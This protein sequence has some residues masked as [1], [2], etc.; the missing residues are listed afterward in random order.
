MVFKDLKVRKDEKRAEDRVPWD[1]P[2]FRGQADAQ[3]P[4]RQGAVGRA[5]KAVSQKTREKNVQ[6]ERSNCLC[7]LLLKC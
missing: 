1:M 4:E 2:K 6:E 5:E 7:Q 3:Q